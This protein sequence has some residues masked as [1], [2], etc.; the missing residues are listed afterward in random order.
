M[1]TP[2]ALTAECD[3]LSAVGAVWLLAVFGGM[4][5]VGLFALK[6]RMKVAGGKLGETK[7]THRIG[8]RRCAR[9][10][11]GR[12]KLAVGTFVM[13]PAGARDLFDGVTGGCGSPCGRA[14][15]PA[16]FIGPAGAGASGD[17]QL[18]FH[19]KQRGARGI[20]VDHAAAT[21]SASPARATAPP[22]LRVIGCGSGE[23]IRGTRPSGGVPEI[24]AAA[25]E[26]REV[27][28]SFR[29]L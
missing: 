11:A 22:L 25:R 5:P 10:S 9:A 14:F 12:M 20:V 26:G 19:R 7:R 24:A 21:T 15:P 17:G 13:R 27:F 16:T 2:T 18:L 29:L 8:G 6:A 3:C 28:R 1:A 23:K 4:N